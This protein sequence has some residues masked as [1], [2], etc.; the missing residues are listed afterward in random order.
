M[1]LK[2]TVAPGP[3]AEEGSTAMEAMGGTNNFLKMMEMLCILI[4]VLHRYAHL[5]KLI[6]L[7]MLNR[8]NLSYLNNASITLI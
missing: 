8:C 7:Y 3:Q 1:T 2:Y 6:K 4:V 5:L